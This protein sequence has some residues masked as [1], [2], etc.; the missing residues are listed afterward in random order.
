MPAPP[1]ESETAMVTAMGGD[2]WLIWRL[3]STDGERGRKRAA[4]S[5]PSAGHDPDQV[6]GLAL[7]SQPPVTDGTPTRWKRCSRRLPPLQGGRRRLSL[8]RGEAFVQRV[9]APDGARWRAGLSAV[10]RIAARLR[11]GGCIFFTR[12]ASPEMP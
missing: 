3:A 12:A 10:R 11:H 4:V 2:F 9:P 8:V 1:L 6:R 7:A 5:V